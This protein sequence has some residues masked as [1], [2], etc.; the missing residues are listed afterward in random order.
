MERAE[1]GQTV[2]I[3]YTGR[4]ADGTVFDTSAE[5][6]PLQFTLGEGQVIPGFE[7][8]VLGMEQGQQQT[9][10]IPSTEAYGEA[11]ED[12]VFSVPRIQLPSDIQPNV[13]QR[14][15]MQQDGQVSVVVVREVTDEAVTLDANHPLAGQDLI[16]DLELVGIG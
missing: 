2:Q 11:R 7:Q 1:R 3:H 6:D 15:Q 8:A 9:V 4:L 13:G 14:L 16:F 10:T 5:R 12:L